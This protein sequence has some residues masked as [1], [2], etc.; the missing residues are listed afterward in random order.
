MLN[1]LNGSDR[2][3]GTPGHGRRLLFFRNRV[4]IAV[5]PVA[6]ERA[7]P[8]TDRPVGRPNRVE[9]HARLERYTR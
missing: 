9:I 3:G 5:Q 7:R 8:W 1:V 4:Q 2:S 6:P